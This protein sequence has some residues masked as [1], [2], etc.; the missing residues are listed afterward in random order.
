[1]TAADNRGKIELTSNINSHMTLSLIS[2]PCGVG[3][4]LRQFH[5]VEQTH[6]G[7]QRLPGVLHLWTM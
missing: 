1:M 7:H 6:D 2:G 5:K 3:V 4:N